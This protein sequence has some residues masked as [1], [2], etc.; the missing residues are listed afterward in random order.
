MTGPSAKLGELSIG[1]T[2]QGAGLYLRRGGLQVGIEH[3]WS[4]QTRAGLFYRASF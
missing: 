4:G 2:L 3:G 1:L